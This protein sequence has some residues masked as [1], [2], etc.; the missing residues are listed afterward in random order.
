MVVNKF[1]DSLPLG[2]H[3]MTNEPNNRRKIK[4]M[5]IGKSP[6]FPLT[7]LMIAVHYIAISVSLSTKL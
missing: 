7:P 3:D 5:Y 1:H 6:D 2:N 4:L